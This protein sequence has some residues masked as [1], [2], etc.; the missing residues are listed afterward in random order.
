MGW[1]ATPKIE[2]GGQGER[3][4]QVTKWMDSRMFS[5]LQSAHQSSRYDMPASAI[6]SSTR[7]FSGV[8]CADYTRERVLLLCFDYAAIYVPKTIHQTHHPDRLH[9]TTSGTMQMTVIRSPREAARRRYYSGDRIPFWSHL[10]GPPLSHLYFLCPLVQ[11][12]GVNIWG[13]SPSPYLV[14]SS[15]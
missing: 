7:N 4:P 15:L 11:G 10:E 5:R 8:Q 9:N 12:K 3:M 6:K 14:P 1:N 2:R 13:P